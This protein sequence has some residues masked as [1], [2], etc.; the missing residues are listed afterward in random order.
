MKLL[1]KT[2]LVILVVMLP[3]GLTGGWLLYKLVDYAIISDVDEQLNRRM[4]HLK[5]RRERM[6][7]RPLESLG[8]DSDVEIRSA[9][10]A[11][12][13]PP[14]YVSDFKRGRDGK[15]I[16]VRI[17]KSSL[18]MLGKNYVVTLKQIYDQQQKLTWNISV[19]VVGTYWILLALTGIV[20]LQISKGLWR[21][22]Y[23]LLDRIREYRI[24]QPGHLNV[25]ISSTAEFKELNHTLTAFTQYVTNQYIS[26]R[27]FSENASHEIQTPLAIA[28]GN[29]DTLMQSNNLHESDLRRV[30]Q[31]KEALQRLSN[32]SQTLLL[33]T[34]IDNHQFV[35]NSQINVSAMLTE[36]VAMYK[37]FTSH[38]NLHFHTSIQTDII[39]EAHPYLMEI[40][41]ANLIKN[42]VRHNLDGGSIYLSLTPSHLSIINTGQCL[43]FPADQLFDRFSKDPA[44][45]ESTGLGLAI[46][47]QIVSLHNMR[48][49][50]TYAGET[51][52]HTFLVFFEQTLAV[53]SGNSE[54][55][56]RKV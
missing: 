36:I 25:P 5:E 56:L 38:Q 51:S 53:K 18:T 47:K 10:P 6:P 1:N 15:K 2:V 7:D 30:Y 41:F 21:P 13:Q 34:K 35:V 31:S 39:L 44:N 14:V 46:V 40:L 26:Q 27:Q 3:F 45:Q 55:S 29:L 8:L 23:E 19:I 11:F 49:Q 54:E 9:G 4:M 42:A 32:L 48:I 17:L 22:F 28:L 24:D 37:E 50:Y 33:L 12:H 52:K 20:I 16:K 43:P